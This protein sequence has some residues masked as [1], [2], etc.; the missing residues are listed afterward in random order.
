MSPL[1]VCVLD[2]FASTGGLLRTYAGQDV[3]FALQVRARERASMCMPMSI[4]M[5]VCISIYRRGPGRQH[6]TARNSNF[7]LDLLDHVF[8]SAFPERF[9]LAGFGS[10]FHNCRAAYA[11]Y[12]LLLP[13]LQFF[14]THHIFNTC[15]F[16]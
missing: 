11:L 13:T 14:P 15:T 8:K 12:C 3:R 7:P 1:V 6:G 2:K 4:R 10:G 16:S 5:C 9:P